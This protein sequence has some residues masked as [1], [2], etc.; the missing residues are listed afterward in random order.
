M[1]IALMIHELLVEGGGERQCIE[2]A[3]ALARNGHQVAIFTSAYDRVHCFPDLCRNLNIVD[4]GRGPLRW[5]RKPLPLRGFL[6]MRRLVAHVRQPFEIWNPHHWPAQWG[7]AWLK[8]KLG[9]KV[10]WNCNDVPIFY[11]KA[12]Q[13]Q[14]FSDTFRAALQW[15]YYLCDRSQN[16]N[17][18]LTLLLSNWAEDNF[19]AIYSGPTRIVRAGVDC[20]RFTPGG[21]RTKIRGRFGYAPDQFVLLW[22]GIFMPHRRLQDAIHAVS[23]LQSRGFHVNLLLGGSD[24]SYPDYFQSLKILTRDLGIE[25]RVTF[26]GKVEEHEIR[27][28]YCACDAFLFPNEHQTW[29]L[30]VFE[31][32]ACGAPVLVSQGAAVS[33]ALTDHETAL[34]FPPRNPDVLAD[35]I[36]LIVTKPELR[37]K[38]A[39]N[40]LKLAGATYTWDRFA[41]EFYEACTDV[42]RVERSSGPLAGSVAAQQ[43]N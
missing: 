2:L 17:V 6:D 23:R 5:L 33:E 10:I 4:I 1:K 38:I 21:D 18:D 40:G 8:R 31:A 39:R 16:S 25:D 41:D 34:L 42:I 12:H 20:G 30:A 13:R 9:G 28:F 35:K 27:D 37:E 24:R 32:M 19:K 3:R 7:A 43:I 36:E 29:G 26:S 14:T 15:V 22:L 11:E